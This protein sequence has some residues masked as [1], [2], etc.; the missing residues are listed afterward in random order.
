M[1]LNIEQKKL[2]QMEPAGHCLIK[3]VAGSGK[4][5]VAVHRISH[6]LRHYCFEPDDRVLMVTFNRTLLS[7]I[8]YL[9]EKVENPDDQ[10]GIAELMNNNDKVEIKTI[11]SIIYAHYKKATRANEINIASQADTYRIMARA[12]QILLEDKNTHK[13]IDLK[14]VKFLIDEI[15]W[16]DACL[17]DTLEDYQVADR[18]GRSSSTSDNSPQKL[19]KNSDSRSSI[20]KL[21]E[22]YLKL[23]DQ[24]HLTNFRSMNRIALASPIKSTDKYTHILIDEGQDLTRAQL[25]M[26]KM[27]Y[28]QKSYSSL[29]FIADNAQ[30]IYPHSW[31]GKGRSYSSIGLDMSGKSRTLAKNYRT[32]TQISEAAYSLLEKDEQLKSD[33]DF[34]KPSLV[35]R[36]GHYPI[37]SHFSTLKEELS[38]VSK[39]VMA[40]QSE[41]SLSDICILAKSRRLTEEVKLFLDSENIPSVTINKDTPDFDCDAVKISTLH[42]IKGLEFRV[43]MIISLNEGIIPYSSEASL[44]DDK[45]IETDE[46]K[47]LYVGM[48]RANELLYLSSHQKPSRFIREIDTSYLRFRRNSVIKP[49]YPIA[50]TE[51]L[52]KEQIIDLYSK[53]EVIRQ[54]LLR[55]LVVSYGFP[56]KLIDIEY[57]IMEFSRKGYA[58]IVVSIY[59]QGKRVPYFI[60]ETKKYKSGVVDAIKQ[61]ESYMNHLPTVRYC[62]VSDGF[63]LKIFDRKLEEVEDFPRFNHSMLP[64]TTERFVLKSFRGQQE[65]ICECDTNDPSQCNFIHRDSKLSIDFFSYS[66]INVYG[67]IVAGAPKD[68]NSEI[69]GKFVLPSDYLIQPSKAFILKVVGD[70]MRDAGIDIGDFVIVHQ[71]NTAE[72]GQ[73]VVAVLD[74]EATLKRFMQMGDTVLLIPE[75]SKY[76]PINVKPDQVLING[77]V[78]G[79]LKN[80]RA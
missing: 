59:S 31:L 20:F 62:A 4:T 69:K 57:P 8:K 27:I 11:D 76:E 52:K 50:I 38:I 26:L 54:W 2:I 49:L 77:V 66:E 7:Y 22:I 28:R 21:R 5:T 25:E 70:S 58:D 67:D 56:E 63:D 68:I 37:Y 10:I 14:N 75:N 18:M 61:V 24:E 3:G 48:T 39:T 65:I 35:D 16:I 36:Q 6:L 74:Y 12:V 60:I 19:Q 80:I 55:E 40:L 53:E 30:S 71:Q 29:T 73:I 23:F 78:I 47:L 1:Q 51:F 43:V 34:V 9:Y 45:S 33:L 32:T 17:I 79:V 64:N 44:D 13:I 15:E 46:R 42:S 72:N 41:Y